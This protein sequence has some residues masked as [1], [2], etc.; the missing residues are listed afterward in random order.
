MTA[1]HVMEQFPK[2]HANG[3]HFF[4]GSNVMIGAFTALMG[5]FGKNAGIVIGDNTKIAQ[6]V[7][8]VSGSH[9]YLDKTM[10]ID[11]Q[12]SVYKTVTIGSDCW[13]GANSTILYGR[14]IG[15]GAV[16][17]AGSVVT[18]DIPE[19]EVWAGVPAKKIKERV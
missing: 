3:N 17:G 18:K 15:N 9:N 19:Y 13:I 2:V 16:V 6:G 5:G 1:D 11:E 7:V 12:S 8:I 10:T 4:I 14:T